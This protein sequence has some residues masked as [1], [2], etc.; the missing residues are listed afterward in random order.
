MSL[1]TL[2]RRSLTVAA[3]IAFST[4][5]GACGLVGTRGEG[6][7]IAE[8]RQTDAF[9]GIESGGGVHVA[10]T[11]G[12]ASSLAIQAQ[13]NILP[14]IVTEVVDG[15]LRIRSSKG[16]TT[17]ETVD[18]TIT[19]PHLDRIVLNGGSHGDIDGLTAD[20]LD[21]RVSG[22]AVLTANGTAKALSLDFN[23]GSVGHMDGLTATTIKLDLTGGSRVDVRAT[24]LVSGSA[25]GGSHVSVAGGAEASVNTTGGSE[26]E[27]H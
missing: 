23:G 7:V 26:V 11:I 10:V 2:G 15:T 5:V 6:A 22:G 1:P 20:V 14:L 13:A 27:Q 17:S 18:V 25:T 8:S 4:S 24:E 19:T 21:V 3:V 12:P 9:S 16:Y